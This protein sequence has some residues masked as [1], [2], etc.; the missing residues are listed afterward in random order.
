M[1]CLSLYN[2]IRNHS[3]DKFQSN[4]F[5]HRN[6]VDLID[7]QGFQG[8]ALLKG[9]STKLINILLIYRKQSSILTSFYGALATLT[10]TEDIH[11]I[12]GDFYI[13]TFVQ[14][15]RVEAILRAFNTPFG[16]SYRPLLYKQ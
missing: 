16:F 14:D 11:T 4:A 3:F 13:N 7:F 12:L 10:T 6:E 2:V 8:V 5:C 1:S 15:L 9:F